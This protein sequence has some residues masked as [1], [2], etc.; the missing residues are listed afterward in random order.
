MGSADEYRIKL[1]RIKESL[2]RF[3]HESV[4]SAVIQGMRG[5]GDQ[6]RVTRLP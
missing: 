5:E 4:V 2:S 3:S 6:N 1:A